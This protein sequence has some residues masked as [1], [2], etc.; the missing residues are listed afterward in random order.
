[1]SFKI[2]WELGEIYTAP[3][4]FFLILLGMSYSSY[5][6]GVFFNWRI[7]LF[8]LTLSF[9]HVAVNIFNNYMDYQN[10]KDE[11]YKTKTNI[12]GREQL[13]LS[14]VRKLF[15]V[16]LLLSMVTGAILTWS[17][18]YF[19]LL[20]G[21]VGYYVGLGYSYGI[22]PINSLPIAE[23]IPAVLSGYM[24]PAMSVYLTAYG[25]TEI[26][27]SFWGQT[28]LAFSPM[29]LCMFNNLLA[30]NTCDLEEDIRNNRKTLV[31]YIG[32]KQSVRLLLVFL[33]LSFLVM[34]ASVFLQAAPPTVLLSLLLLP[35]IIKL[36]QPYVRAQ[37][38]TQTFPLVLKAMSLMMVLYPVFY[39][40]GSFSY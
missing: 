28:L 2:I 27:G 11:E 37:I 34:V 31:Y 30:N 4:N 40:L 17:S 8:T 25:K 18:D 19:I 38:K 6:Y 33:G 21:I 39:L 22:R 10:A 20:L 26:N 3:L 35:L 1:M 36:I 29:V 7:L 13:K 9:I 5:H 16:F 12:I 32:K 14:T 23:T 24:I 15:F